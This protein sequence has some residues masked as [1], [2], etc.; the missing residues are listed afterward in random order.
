M[1]L[2]V[3]PCNITLKMASNT[4]IFASVSYSEFGYDIN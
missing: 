3:G 4:V 2:S 1:E